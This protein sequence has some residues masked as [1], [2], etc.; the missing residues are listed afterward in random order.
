MPLQNMK[1]DRSIFR[2]VTVAQQLKQQSFHFQ[3]KTLAPLVKRQSLN[4]QNRYCIAIVKTALEDP[5]IPSKR[6]TS[7]RTSLIDIF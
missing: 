4:F 3:N 6:L 1:G 2:T 7:R 5:V